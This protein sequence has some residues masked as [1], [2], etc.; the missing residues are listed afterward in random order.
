MNYFG[1]AARSSKICSSRK[2]AELKPNKHF[3]SPDLDVSNKMIDS[4]SKITI[5]QATMTFKANNTQIKNFVGAKYTRKM[6]SV[7]MENTPVANEK[8]FSFMCVCAFGENISIVNGVKV[9]KTVKELAKKYRNRVRPLLNEGFLIKNIEPLQVT[10]PGSN[11]ILEYDYDNLNEYIGK[12][13]HIDDN[14]EKIEKL[15]EELDEKLEEKKKYVSLSRTTKIPTKSLK[16]K[17][18]KSLHVDDV[19]SMKEDDGEV[20]EIKICDLNEESILSKNEGEEM[21]VSFI[22]DD[23]YLIK[24]DDRDNNNVEGKRVKETSS[25]E[26]LRKSLNEVELWIENEN[27]NDTLSS[28]VEEINHSFINKTFG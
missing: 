2:Q 4:F 18:E 5:P 1:K 12:Q 28:I 25:D 8:L 17:T 7:E 19:F 22:N 24:R 16:E 3:A 27:K 14:A 9:S 11:K 23:S 26:E 13:K 21:C 10:P 20:E 6:Y 15:E